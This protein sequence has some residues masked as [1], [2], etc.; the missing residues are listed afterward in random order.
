VFLDRK[1]IKKHN[2]IPHFCNVIKGV[3]ES[4]GVEITMNCNQIA[5]EWIVEFVKIQ[6]DEVDQ[7]EQMEAKSP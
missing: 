6:T 4:E 3:D 1:W 5:F 7:L 2:S